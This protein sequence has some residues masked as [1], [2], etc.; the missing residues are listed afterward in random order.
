[1]T[2]R[3]GDTPRVIVA[4]A[5]IAGLATGRFLRERAAELSVTVLEASSRVGGAIG[6]HRDGDLT[7]EQGAHAFL[8]R[9]P[10][11]LSLAVGLGLEDRLLTGC[12][13]RRRRFIFSQ[14]RLERFPDGPGSF[15]GTG[16]L[17]PWS[18]ARMLVEPLVPRRRR[19][20]DES[21]GSFARRRL[22]SGAA[23]RLVEP[24]VGGI[25][26]GDPEGLSVRSVLP[27]LAGLEASG[28]SLLSAYL[29]QR[30]QGSADSGRS[31]TVPGRSR[32]VSLVGGLQELTS[33]LGA[34]LGD[35]LQLESPVEG[36]QRDG[37]EW[38][39]SVGGPRSRELRADV[40]V[41]AL[42]APAT[43]RLLARVDP[44]MAALASSVCYS[45]VAVTGFA[46]R[47]AEIPHP[48]DGFGH[49]LAGDEDGCVLGVYWSSSVFPG[50]RAPRGTV[51]LQAFLGG[52]RDPGICER[53][54]EAILGLA[55]EHLDKSLGVS[56]APTKARVFRHPLGLPQYG[57]G[58]SLRLAA[59]ERGLAR[60]P[61]LHLT[62]SAWRGS[63]I[64]SCTADAARVVDQILAE[65]PAGMSETAGKR[66]GART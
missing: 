36:L 59:V 7:L 34:S 58:H 43:G 33:A 50:Q 5:G 57:L 14:G 24:V 11:T 60:W 29:K 9:H 31:P 45:P 66:T 37:D 10:S 38:V 15:L 20:E 30:W 21:V 32:L 44:E 46:F 16:L 26:A 6:T 13:E 27:Q 42:P 1:M 22:G 25:Y 55:L 41:G 18:K 2:R 56:A 65:H 23:V 8:N 61:G 62:G 63:G 52:A 51:V 19:G 4:G 47:E 48:L 39:V 53:D 28:R 54:D 35:D 17:S 3:D 49:L 40:V 64:N 12:E